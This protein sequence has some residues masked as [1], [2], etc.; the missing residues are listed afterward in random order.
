MRLNSDYT[1]PITQDL[2]RIYSIA[3][4]ICLMYTKKALFK[5]AR[6][7]YELFEDES[8]QYMVEPYYDVIDG[9]EHVD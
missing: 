3:G 4:E 2:K 6:I 8:Y 9:L 7:T 5:V 1:T